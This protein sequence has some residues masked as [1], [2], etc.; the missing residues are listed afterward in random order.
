MAFDL[1]RLPPTNLSIGQHPDFEQLMKLYNSALQNISELNG[2]LQE[3][4]NPELLLHTF[5]LHE[6]IKSSAIE[7]IHTTIE[8]VLEDESNMERE[9]GKVR[10]VNKEV[11]RYR[12]AITEGQKQMKKYGLSSR[13]I[14]S[15][16]KTLGITK[17]NP[18]EFRKT[19]NNLSSE[20]SDGT[21]I[22]YTPP[23]ASHVNDLIGN[24]EHYVNENED[25]FPLIKTA[26]CHYQFEAIH[27]FLDGN[28][29]TGRILLV[30]QLIR[31]GMLDFPVLFISSYLNKEW[32]KNTRD[33]F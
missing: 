20:S 9:K 15:I 29:R 22:I 6:S 30:L 23:I 18:G 8:S 5:Y 33:Y 13:T 12:A 28:G 25:S 21:I 14:K 4:E 16:H 1:P 3:V 11:I 19:Q 17:G 32:T 7:N 31:E 2:A 27:P 10:K 24:W 26:I